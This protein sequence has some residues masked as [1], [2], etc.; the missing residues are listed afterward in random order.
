MSSRAT[1]CS[2]GPERECVWLPRHV[3]S[4]RPPRPRMS[5]DTA[6]A[7]GKRPRCSSYACCVGLCLQMPQSTRCDRACWTS[8]WMAAPR[9]PRFEDNFAPPQM[10]PNWRLAAAKRSMIAP[11][12]EHEANR[13]V[14]VVL[15]VLEISAR[16]RL[17]Y[18]RGRWEIFY[19]DRGWY[20]VSSRD[21]T[22]YKS[23]YYC[24]ESACQQGENTFY[25]AVHVST[26]PGKRA[27]E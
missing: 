7:Y 15:D 27:S 25:F 19:A 11:C 12:S 24:G 13:R 26:G 17:R 14:G 2:S 21:K 10:K 22:L 18:R 3:S 20:P 1:G 4:L 8:R 16:V 5:A 6:G 9:P 23:V